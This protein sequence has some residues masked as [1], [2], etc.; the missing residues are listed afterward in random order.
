MI[1]GW[2]QLAAW[3]PRLLLALGALVA[4]LIVVVITRNVVEI[5]RR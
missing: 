1:S 5:F 2:W 4:V 3:T